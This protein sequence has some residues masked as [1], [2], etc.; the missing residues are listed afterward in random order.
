[1]LVSVDVD[2]KTSVSCGEWF[3]WYITY[4]LELWCFF[5]FFLSFLRVR[6]LLRRIFGTLCYLYW[7][8]LCEHGERWRNNRLWLVF[9][10]QLGGCFGLCCRLLFEVVRWLSV[11]RVARSCNLS[12]LSFDASRYWYS[13][14]IR[15]PPSLL[16]L[17]LSLYILDISS[18]MSALFVVCAQHL[19]SSCKSVFAVP[20]SGPSKHVRS[21]CCSPR[22]SIWRSS[23]TVV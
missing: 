19:R 15:F 16:S 8:D 17:S 20:D 22:C 12:F 11:P 13:P 21:G 1:M 5:L 10:I 7:T 2:R 4:L 9:F 23:L 18:I 3:F 14:L 6:T